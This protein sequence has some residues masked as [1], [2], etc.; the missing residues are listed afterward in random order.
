MRKV[1]AS[2]SAPKG[3]QAH[4]PGQRPGVPTQACTFAQK[5]QKLY[6]IALFY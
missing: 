1:E 3:Q 6:Y 5:G 2:K 4:S